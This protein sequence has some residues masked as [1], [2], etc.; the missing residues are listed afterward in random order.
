MSITSLENKDKIII[1]KHIIIFDVNGIVLELLEGE[2]RTEEFPPLTRHRPMA[3]C[4]RFKTRTSF[5]YVELIPLQEVCHVGS[6]KNLVL[7]TG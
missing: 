2:W 1:N 5:T 6:P 7:S 4:N 3:G